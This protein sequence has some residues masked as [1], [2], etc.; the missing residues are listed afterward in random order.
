[1]HG[2]AAEP[3]VLHPAPR[4]G[5][6]AHL[7]PVPSLRRA[8]SQFLARV[9]RA[10][11]GDEG[12]IQQG[13]GGARRDGSHRGLRDAQV[14]PP[15]CI[16]HRGSSGPRRR[17]GPSR[18][19]LRD[20]LLAQIRGPETK[21]HLPRGTG[22]GPHQGHR[23][24]P[25]RPT[26]RRPPYRWPRIVAVREERVRRRSPPGVQAPARD[27]PRQRQPAAYQGGPAIP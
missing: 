2:P 9:A 6:K 25:G 19:L 21:L 22:D 8:D 17:E 18:T 20:D 10:G 13:P 3:Q 15:S 12:E 23:R 14:S 1:M 11:E 27:R 4:Q 24:S 5:Q 16:E 26:A 7:P